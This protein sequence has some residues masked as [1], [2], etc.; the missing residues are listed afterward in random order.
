M[1]ILYGA[2][3]LLLSLGISTSCVKGGGGSPQGSTP[4]SSEPQNM[5]P[6][7]MVAAENSNPTTPTNSNPDP[8][9]AKTNDPLNSN[10]FVGVW[11]YHDGAKFHTISIVE[12]H[13]SGFAYKLTDD[14]GG[15]GLFRCSLTN[16]TTLFCNNN[17]SITYSA[18][19][20]AS[21]SYKNNSYYLKGTAPIVQDQF[22]GNWYSSALKLSLKIVKNAGKYVVDETHDN[23]SSK[24]GYNYKAK[25]DS[26][27][28]VVIIDKEVFENEYL[29]YEREGPNIGKLCDKKNHFN[30]NTSGIVQCFSKR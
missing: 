7:N 24:N 30:S 29:T 11:E 19:N 12:E 13:V 5:T 21:I 9:A 10:N 1:K 14:D 26:L 28:S 17:Q 15:I 4:Q 3:V 2:V 27:V 16:S 18:S 6:A 25:G 20:P 23:G 8:A 22:L